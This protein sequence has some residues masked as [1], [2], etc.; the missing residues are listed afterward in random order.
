MNEKVKEALKDIEIFFK[1]CELENK[2]DKQLT[3]HFLQCKKVIEQLLIDFDKYHESQQD[4]I[5]GKDEYIAKL[6]NDRAELKEQL[7]QVDDFKYHY[8]RYKKEL[9]NN[10]KV[11]NSMQEEATTNYNLVN[12][13]EDRNDRLVER[14]EKQKAKIKSLEL[15]IATIV[16][17]PFEDNKP[18]AMELYRLDSNDIVDLVKFAEIMA[19]NIVFTHVNGNL[20][21]YL[22]GDMIKVNGE[23][24]EPVRKVVEKYGR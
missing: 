16:G 17:N 15:Q 21:V 6:C 1:Q 12:Q 9:A 4:L 18:K 24:F 2:Y 19:R 7:K 11:I 20:Y 5:K 23:P 22:K 3:D 10:L 8:G 14:L 13:L